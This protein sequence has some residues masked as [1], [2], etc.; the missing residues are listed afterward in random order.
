MTSLRFRIIL[1]TF[2]IMF[3][4]IA[5]S[6]LV[7]QDI[8][9]GIIKGDFHDRGFLLANNLASEIADSLLVNDLVG[10]RNSVEN[11][12]KNHPDIE[13]IFVTD[14]AGI[15]LVHTFENGFP[16][17]FKNM[18][19][20]SNAM[21][22]RVFDTDKGIIHDFDIPIFKNIGYVHLGLSENK[23]REQIADASRKLMLLSISVLVFGGVF[24]YFTGRWLTEPILKLT[25]GAKRINSGVLDRKI[26]I[27]SRDELGELA[28][29][30]ND[31]A[32]H[33]DQKIRDIVVSKEQTETAQKYLETLF[34]NIDDGIVVLNINHGI[35]KAN[36]SFLDMMG[37][38]EQ[39]VLGKTCH[40][41]IFKN[42][43]S[44]Q[45]KEEC[46]VNKL[47]ETK[48]PIRI[49]HEAYPG[50]NK[51][52]LELNAS[53]FS[54]KKG[55]TNIILVA[56]DVT[57]QKNLE[58]EII[59]RNRELTLLNEISKNLSEIFDLD[60]LLSNTLENLLKLTRMENGEVHLLDETKGD[61]FLKSRTGKGKI[62]LPETTI[63][64]MGKSG[65]VMILEDAHEFPGMKSIISQGSFFSVPLKSK[66]KVLGIITL[67]DQ[68]PRQFSDSDKKLFSALGSQ[69][70][71]ALENIFFY[72]NIKYLNDFNEEILNNVNLAIHVVDN[73]LKI[74]AINNELLNL[75]RGRLKKENILNKSIYEVYP[76]LKGKNA[77]KEYE[78]VL[79]TGEI[80]QSED[81]TEYY[82]DTIYTSTSKIPIK[83]KK[84]NVEKIITVMKD[85]TAQRRLEEELKDSYEELRLTYLK[86]KEL[87]QMK[88]SFLSNISHELRT[89]LT[90]IIG[91]TEL[92]LDENVTEGQRQK[93]ETILR[94]SKR[95]SR[96][97]NGLL[98]T[99]LIESKSLQLDLQMLSIHDIVAMAAE[100]MKSMA[101][102]KSVPMY[103]EI[104]H[105][106]MIE[107]DRDRLTQIFSYLI[108]NAIKFTIKGEIR[109]TAVEENN[110]AH[111]KISDTGIGIPGD[112]LEFIFDKFYHV[113]SSDS[114]K[115]GGTGLSLWVSKNI[116]EAHSGKIW[117]ESKNT[118]S[119]F[120]ILLPK[121][122]KMNE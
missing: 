3:L 69:I 109:I 97:I 26:D 90:S 65:E 101:S 58:D 98:D 63:N 23:I 8:Q 49:I 60:K 117:A 72:N 29:T 21:T 43:P 95:L 51:K 82:G 92:I 41:L 100:D 102:I 93:L 47:L 120:H 66:D 40:Q 79:K 42:K 12:K 6:Y 2:L 9:T 108:D 105:S 19:G 76:F 10:V 27:N 64:Q 46:P 56:R 14:S 33:L 53:L 85:V 107:G 59:E 78:Y 86:L 15:V 44:Q 22:E 54:D 67:H 111:I 71:V 112:K 62:I 87:Y 119:T 103:I 17:A 50:G 13:Y 74:L 70:G 30:I 91:Y 16:K 89:P 88:E 35:I 84:G 68:K 61:F 106:L 1:S 80:F 11:L 75:S 99:T 55:M 118:G 81:K 39:Q 36:K 24:I 94:N 45:Q 5:G 20:P 37:L 104:P 48:T 83:D 114:Q 38:N 57:Q 116:V 113:E 115:Y 77:D 34:E 73:D 28:R 32:S 18:T 7:I 122:R 121:R 110:C 31:M 4:I 25:E 96:L 52:I